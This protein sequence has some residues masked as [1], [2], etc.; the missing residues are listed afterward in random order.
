MKKFVL[1]FVL[2]AIV[3]FLISANTQHIPSGAPYRTEYV[4]K[5]EGRFGG[6]IEIATKYYD[7]VPLWVRIGSEYVFLFIV[8]AVLIF[9]YLIAEPK[10]VKFLKKP[11]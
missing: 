11:W 7:L 9:L 10:P 6:D 3:G 8:P 5:N 2:L 4:E 1:V